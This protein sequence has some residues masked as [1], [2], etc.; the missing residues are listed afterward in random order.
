[1]LSLH[2][3]YELNKQYQIVQIYLKTLQ[4]EILNC[5]YVL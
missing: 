4:Y 2:Q 1:M 5:I 3:W